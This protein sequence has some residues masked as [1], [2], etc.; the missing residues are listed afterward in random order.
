MT[1]AQAAICVGDLVTA[2]YFAQALQQPDGTWA[3][4]ASSQAP[5]NVNA[6]KTFA[7]AHGVTAR[8]NTAE[9]S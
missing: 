8:V 1:K 4:I 3:V 5:I 7:D 6:V 2:G 9:L